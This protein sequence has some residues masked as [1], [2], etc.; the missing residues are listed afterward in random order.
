[1]SSIFQQG[2]FTVLS[3]E[4]YISTR[5]QILSCYKEMSLMDIKWEKEN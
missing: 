3:K 2:T 5:K 1:M 4:A